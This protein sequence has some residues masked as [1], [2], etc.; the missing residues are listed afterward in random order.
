MFSA[1]FLMVN[2]LSG[3][4][5]N[6]AI[7]EF[8]LGVELV[9]SD[10]ESAILY[11]E[12]CIE[13]C[14]NLGEEAAEIREKAVSQVPKVYYNV[15]M[16][17]F[18][19]KNYDKAITEFENTA[20]AADKYGDSETGNKA[21]MAI[22]QLY[23]A[24][25]NDLLRDG[26]NTGAIANYDKA[27]ELSPRYARAYLHKGLALKELNELM[28][29]KDALLKA[30]ELSGKDEKTRTTAE[31]QMRVN[32]YNAS[33]LA[34]EN[35][36]LEKAEE[37]L[38]I[39]AEYGNTITDIYLK[40]GESFND[41]GQYSR[42]IEYL[43]M[44]LQLESGDATAKAGFHFHLGNAYKAMNNVAKACESYK[45]A[46]HGDYLENAKY[47]IEQVLKCN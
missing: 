10:P 18:R 32:F 9:T 14:D 37:Y 4:T 42:A 19:E 33:V 12:K 15:A 26:D 31:G 47:Q 24:K 38:N 41:K 3:Q 11:F 8:N 23:W 13:I 25:G 45:N 1:T 20:G 16:T 40:L 5:L 7:A 46:L 2:R 28:D 35:K 22:P 36:E 29:M 21:R 34:F 17:Y 43:T 39:S 30:I 44:G 6:D 27:I